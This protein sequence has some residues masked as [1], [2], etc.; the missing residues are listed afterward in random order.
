MQSLRDRI[1]VDAAQ[2][3][4]GGGTW[5]FKGCPGGWIRLAAHRLRG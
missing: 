4:L 1:N 5:P 3:T 2:P